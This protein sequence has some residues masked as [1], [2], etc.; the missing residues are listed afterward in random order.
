MFSLNKSGIKKQ[1]AKNI[2]FIDFIE[3]IRAQT[4][5]FKETVFAIHKNTA[6]N[7][8]ILLNIN[9]KCNAFLHN[10]K[11]KLRIL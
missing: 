7:Q 3:F 1:S 10:N 9:I 2:D 4:D 8:S 11:I 6:S 5:I